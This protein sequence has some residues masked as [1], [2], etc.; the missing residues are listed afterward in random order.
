MQFHHRGANLPWVWACCH[1]RCADQG[2]TPVLHDQQNAAF[3]GVCWLCMMR[4]T[5]GLYRARRQLTQ[6]QY[7][8][9][10]ALHRIHFGA[11]STSW[12]TRLGVALWSFGS[13]QDAVSYRPARAGLCVRW[14]GQACTFQRRRFCAAQ[15]AHAP[16][17]LHRHHV[18]DS[19]PGSQAVDGA[20]G[21]RSQPAE[22][23]D[24]VLGELQFREGWADMLG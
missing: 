7:C 22:G 13:V 4:S 12:H 20:G 6:L 1:R 16:T 5:L 3:L 2:P 21:D 10:R 15:V 24:A 14:S 23:T 9:P 17:W 18:E 8:E 11:A 19:Q